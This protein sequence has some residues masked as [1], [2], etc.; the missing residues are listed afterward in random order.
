MRNCV[1]IMEGRHV[2]V[3][4]MDAASNT[5]VGD[6]REKSKVLAAP[7]PPVISLI[8]DEVHM[9]SVNARVQRILKTLEEPPE[10]VKSSSRRP[11]SA[12]FL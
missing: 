5:G 6:I 2:D 7:R 1:A 9:L 3:M 11:K 12:R 8:I 4:E 10:H